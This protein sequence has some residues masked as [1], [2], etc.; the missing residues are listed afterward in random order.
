MWSVQT[1]EYYLAVKRDEVLICA[2]AWMDLEML[3]YLK[4]EATYQ[5]VPFI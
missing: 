4:E 1:V 5:M 3:P 2:S